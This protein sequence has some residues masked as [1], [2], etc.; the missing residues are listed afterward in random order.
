MNQ[1]Q[2]EFEFYQETELRYN[3]EGGDL[4]SD[5]GML[6]VREFDEKIGFSRDISALIGDKR[7]SGSI[8]YE[9]IDMI[10]ERVYFFC[11]G[12]EDCNDVNYLKTDPTFKA[13]LKNET[14][15]SNKIMA[16]QPTL[17]RFENSIDWTDIKKMMRGMIDFWLNQFDKDPD[18]L[19]LDFDTTDDPCH[20]HQQMAM[21]HGYYKQTMYHPLIVTC[22][23]DIVLSLLRPGLYHSNKCTHWI[24]SFIVERIKAKYPHVKLSFRADSGFASPKI[25]AFLET[26]HIDYVIG[27]G[28]NNTL[29]TRNES[30]I[31]EAKHQF[32]TTSEKSR[33]FQSFDYQAES[34]NTTRRIVAKAE[35]TQ[36]GANNR[37]VVTNK[38]GAP[39]DI[40]DGFY[41]QRGCMENDIKAVKNAC[42]A[43]RLSC[44][45]FKANQFR[46]I[47]STMAHQLLQYMRT[48]LKN[49]PLATMS[50]DT[51]RL[52]LFKVA[53]Q[54]IK[55]TRKLWFRFC[56][57]FPYQTHFLTI[58]QNILNFSP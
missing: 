3:F 15:K 26:N 6:L 8:E 13:I 4:S 1:N 5:G 24:V 29:K 41:C 37:F 35:Y 7:K 25:Y 27:F 18:E 53:V 50:I 33:L 21:F 17:S 38:T 55:T 52:R 58:H 49:T 57:S 46:L 36:K 43:D 2:G 28:S 23:G 39:V 51:I 14:K 40:Y 44:H 20:G 32:E 10:R 31:L 42:F 9:M 34:W 45:S 54:V 48:M 16:S 19:T 22:D 11:A 30:L 12:Y 56:S 47:L